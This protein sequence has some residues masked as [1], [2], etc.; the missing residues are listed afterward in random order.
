[1]E[2]LVASAGDFWI[3]G[4]SVQVKNLAGDWVTTGSGPHSILEATATDGQATPVL[5]LHHHDGSD[6]LTVSPATATTDLTINFSKIDDI[7][8]GLTLPVGSVLLDGSIVQVDGS[9]LMPDGATPGIFATGGNVGTLL[10]TGG[11]G[12]ASVQFGGGAGVGGYTFDTSALFL[13]DGGGTSVYSYAST[14]GNITLLGSF[15]NAEP[16]PD[17]SADPP[18]VGASYDFTITMYPPILNLKSSSGATVFS[19]SDTAIYPSVRGPAGPAGAGEP[20]RVYEQT[21]EPTD[22]LPGSVWVLP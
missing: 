10:F 19:V 13:N 1:M 3:N 15:D 12:P 5:D 17:P 20:M 18:V 2:P 4:T 22:A 11:V 6:I 16:A 21:D 9:S 7:T 14:G 8:W